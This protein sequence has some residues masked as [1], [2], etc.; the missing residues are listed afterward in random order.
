M[1]AKCPECFGEKP[2]CASCCGSGLIEVS[3]AVG[4]WYH[5]VCNA[6]DCGVGM[7][8]RPREDLNDCACP[9]CEDMGTK[10]FRLE[11]ATMKDEG[12]S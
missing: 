10:G 5:I 2:E 11:L 3:L 9:E 1:K 12:T 7:T 6:C 4:P 8:S